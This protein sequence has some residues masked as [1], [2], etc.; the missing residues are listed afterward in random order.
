M[1]F[2]FQLVLQVWCVS[3]HSC[4]TCVLVDQCVWLFVPH[5]LEPARLLCPWSS[6][7]KKTG[8]G[9]HAR[10]QHCY[11]FCLS[12]T[13]TLP[14][15]GVT[16]LTPLDDVLG[17][18]PCLAAVLSSVPMTGGVDVFACFCIMFSFMSYVCGF[19]AVSFWKLQGFFTNTE[20][21]SPTRSHAG[22][23]P[24]RKASSSKPVLLPPPG[25]PPVLLSSI[26]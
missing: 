21:V 18:R 20:H 24:R 23:E 5:G 11:E 7:G 17:V 25:W 2:Y 4:Y 19:F 14:L 16:F 8:V 6:P 3:L 15:R 1:A 26:S 10:L 22:R 12:L 9:C 13:P